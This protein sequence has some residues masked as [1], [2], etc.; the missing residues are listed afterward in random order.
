M[1]ESVK[2][3]ILRD[4]KTNE[5]LIP[6]IVGTLGYEP[7][8]EGTLIPPYTND[9]DT[10]GGKTA[11]QF[12]AA[13]H[14]HDYQPKITGT[15]G[16]VIGFDASGNP[17]AQELPS[18]GYSKEETLTNDTKN[19]YKLGESAVPNDVFQALSRFQSGIC[20][21]HV[22]KKSIPG[23]NY[24]ENEYV[25]DLYDYIYQSASQSNYYLNATY[26]KSLAFSEDGSI[27]IIET[28]VPSVAPD[29][30]TA[31]TIWSSYLPFYMKWNNSNEIHKVLHF[32]TI[33]PGNY[34]Y[35]KYHLIESVYSDASVD[36][37]YVNSGNP[38]AY[39]PET[40]DGYEYNYL[41]QL[42]GLCNIVWG[43]YV[44][45]GKYGQSNPNTLTFPFEPKIV[46]ISPTVPLTLGGSTLPVPIPT[47]IRGMTKGLAYGYY[48][49]GSSSY[50]TLTWNG[51]TLS[52][53]N[54]CLSS[55]NEDTEQPIYNP[56]YQLNTKNTTYFY[57]AIG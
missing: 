23:G 29:S 7:D 40:S 17:I 49:Y 45:T 1:S 5:I 12:A 31:H 19:L 57:V 27:Q 4:P 43:S 11:D 41:G 2:Q 36:A 32:P 25:E 24:V 14:T 54:S 47:A 39:P 56:E 50:A 15:E 20:N 16:Q 33:S 53:W 37:G 48:P 26:G 55:Y 9:A 52:W 46:F 3:V 21:D 8:E 38:N 51:N 10:L 30:G 35:T 44:G 13:E 28:F 18:S 22:W 6:K 42:G 34:Y